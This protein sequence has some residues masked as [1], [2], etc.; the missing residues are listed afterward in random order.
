LVLLVA[1]TF[2]AIIYYFAQNSYSVATW[3]NCGNSVAEAQL[4]GCQ[5]DSMMGG[6]LPAE[7]YDRELSDE[8]LEDEEGRWFSDKNLTQP[9]PH[10]E[11][12]K[13]D[14]GSAFTRPDFHFKHCAYMMLRFIVGVKNHQMLDTDA[15]SVGH[16]KHCT[17]ILADPTTDL[18]PYTR[19][20]VGFPSCAKPR[21]SG[22]QELV[23]ESSKSHA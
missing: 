20:N 23:V 11:M 22:W 16:A 3:S 21:R 19:L 8:W 1:L 14:Y 13:G 17:G 6:W 4:R 15:I 5:F 12:R 2:I 10:S 18:G 9:F 7:C